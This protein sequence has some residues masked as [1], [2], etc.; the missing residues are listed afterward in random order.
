M[1]KTRLRRPSGRA[2][3]NKAVRTPGGREW[4][5]VLAASAV[6]KRRAKGL[7]QRLESSGSQGGPSAHER[8]QAGIP[9]GGRLSAI[10]GDAQNGQ[11]K[12]GIIRVEGWPR[13]LPVWYPKNGEGGQVSRGPDRPVSLGYFFSKTLAKMAKTNTITEKA[14]KSSICLTSF[15][16]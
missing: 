14:S 10:L 12:G 1:S 16:E 7:A 6:A 9:P 8:S 15:L 3:R 5:G 13:W 2:P 11:P 4:V